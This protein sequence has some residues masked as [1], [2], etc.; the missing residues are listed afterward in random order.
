MFTANRKQYKEREGKHG[1][2]LPEAS[3]SSLQVVPLKTSA[4]EGN[5]LV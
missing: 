2:Q 4:F 3:L 5:P 1:N